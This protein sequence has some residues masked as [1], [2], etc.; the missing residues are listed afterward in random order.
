M[1]A[2][3][4]LISLYSL[5]AISQPV[6]ARGAA[7]LTAELFDQ[8]VA[9][10]ALYPDPLIAQILMAATYPLEVVEADRWLRIPANAAL[11]GDALTA[12]LQQQSW[13]PSIKSLVAFPRLLHMMDANLN[14]PSSLATPFSRNRRTSWMRFSAF[15]SARKPPA[16]LPQRRS[17]RSRLRIRR[18]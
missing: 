3:V 11:K 7:P 17:R 2:I 6:P 13:D 15:A 14:G 18:S 1:G 10:I 9:P 5:T 12:A 16:H 4:A 8:S